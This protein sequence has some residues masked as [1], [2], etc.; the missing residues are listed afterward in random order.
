MAELLKVGHNSPTQSMNRRIFLQMAGLAT[1]AVMLG[2]VRPV[3][4]A[5]PPAQLQGTRLSYLQWVNFVPAHDT[6]LKKQIAEFEKQSGAKVAFETINMNDIQARTTVAIESKS[7]PDIIQLTHNWPHLYEVG[8]EPVDDLA[9]ELGRKGDGYYDLPK[10]HSFVNGRWRAVPH[11]MVS[12][13]KINLIPFNPWPGAPY[14]CSPPERIAAFAAIV[15]RAGYPAPVRTPRGRDILAACG[16]LKTASERRR[17]N[18][19]AA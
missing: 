13:A 16:Q 14:C 11:S 12:P 4:A 8:L 1:G 17:S 5:Q 6:V 3:T 9:E 7:G 15:R 10:A 19:I 2:G 18:S